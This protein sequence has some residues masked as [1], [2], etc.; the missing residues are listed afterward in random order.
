[1]NVRVNFGQELENLGP[2]SPLRGAATFLP[3]LEG[4]LVYIEPQSQFLAGDA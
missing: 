2:T 4:S 3:A 1:M